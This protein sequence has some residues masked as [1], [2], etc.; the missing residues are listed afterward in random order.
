MNE[1]SPDD[2]GELAEAA[3]R[4][5]DWDFHRVYGGVLA[6]PKGTP[7][8]HAFMLRRLEEKLGELEAGRA[9]QDR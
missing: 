2:D 9:A 1:W 7:F 6:V 3:L 8:A 5:P 4:H